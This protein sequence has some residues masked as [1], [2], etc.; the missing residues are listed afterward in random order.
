[1]GAFSSVTTAYGM[2]RRGQRGPGLGQMPEP[3]AGD[4]TGGTPAPV[5]VAEVGRFFWFPCRNLVLVLSFLSQCL[6]KGGVCRVG[7]EV[8]GMPT[9]SDVRVVLNAA[10]VS[11]TVVSA[12]TNNATVVKAGP[13]LLYGWSVNNINAAVRYLKFY[14][15]A[16]APAPATDAEMLV[17][18]VPTVSGQTVMLPVPLEFDTGIS[19]A[20]VT[21]IAANDNTS[22]SATEHVVTVFYR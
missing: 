21:G 4:P 9:T 1:M 16:S 17:V 18:A 20:L 8:G 13:G 12:N 15:K 19:W 22:V 7:E 14:N 6:E 5:P 10:V 3:R 11:A 2:R